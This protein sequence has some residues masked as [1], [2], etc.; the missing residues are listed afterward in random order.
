[1]PK[2]SRSKVGVKEEGAKRV[3]IQRTLFEVFKLVTKADCSDPPP[4]SDVAVHFEV[5]SAFSEDSAPSRSDEGKT[6]VDAPVEEVARGD[7][8]M[9]QPAVAPEFSRIATSEEQ[10]GSEAIGAGPVPTSP[11]L[12]TDGITLVLSCFESSPLMDLHSAK[13]Q[14]HLLSRLQHVVDVAPV[15]VQV[16]ISTVPVRATREGP[17]QAAQVR[18]NEKAEF[19]LLVKQVTG[20]SNWQEFRDRQRDFWHEP[21]GGRRAF[22]CAH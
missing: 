10:P 15:T 6:A 2:R 18:R 8:E 19:S 14:E 7:W 21:L 4:D 5:P 16:P 12:G 3:G 17:P 20:R 9:K 22:V 1:M 13:Q 11:S